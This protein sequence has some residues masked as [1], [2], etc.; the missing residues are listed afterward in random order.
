MANKARLALVRGGRITLVQNKDERLT[1]PTVKTFRR[2]RWVALARCTKRNCTGI[3]WRV[4]TIA[5]AA[6]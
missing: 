5:K 2:V 3:A 6:T 1:L 4:I